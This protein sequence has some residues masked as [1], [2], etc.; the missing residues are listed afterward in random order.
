MATTAGGVLLVGNGSPAGGHPPHHSTSTIIAGTINLFSLV[1][2]I[3]ALHAFTAARLY[4]VQIMRLLLGVFI[5]NIIISVTY[6]ATTIED[7]LTAGTY[8]KRASL[9][10]VISEFFRWGAMYGCWAQETALAYVSYRS[11]HT[12]TTTQPAAME[13]RVALL[14]TSAFL[15]AGVVRATT[16]SCAGL[17]RHSCTKLSVSSITGNVLTG[18]L[19]GLSILTVV[20]FVRLMLALSAVSSASGQEEA[21]LEVDCTFADLPTTR[22][23][24]QLLFH[25]RVEVAELVRPLRGYPVLYLYF[26]IIVLVAFI[27]T[28]SLD[29]DSAHYANDVSYA[30]LSFK[31]LFVTLLYFFNTPGVRKAV[32][33]PPPC[34][35]SHM[36]HARFNAGDVVESV[37]GESNPAYFLM[38]GV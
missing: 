27:C 10:A 30:L 16:F 5:L 34:C 8:L 36:R 9:G 4:R 38:D 7:V 29:S 18:V 28:L 13:R 26:T 19:L 21:Q 3:V 17:T 32:C 22:R 20:V 35:Q 14:T 24:Q 6:A 12:A 11:L 23:Q 1:L 31:P 37:D 2:L 15:T 25:R 33:T